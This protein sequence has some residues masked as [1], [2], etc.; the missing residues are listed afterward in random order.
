MSYSKNEKSY[1]RKVV[2]TRKE[3][4]DAYI[5]R[6]LISWVVFFLIGCVIGS[7]LTLGFTWLTKDETPKGETPEIETQVSESINKVEP[8]VISLDVS[9]EN[10]FIPLDVPMNTDL[11]KYIYDLCGNDI[12]FPLVMALIKQESSFRPNVISETDDWGLMQI[13]EINHERL[14]DELGVT[15]Y[16][17]PYENT[18]AGVHLL[19]EL[20]EKYELPVMVLMVYKHGEKGASDLWD[21]GVF[22]TTYTNEILKSADEY[23]QQISGK[24]G[25]IK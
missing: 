18:K 25:E 4:E 24:E 1:G 21:E 12:E 14:T 2:K 15:N 13:N 9:T 7:L 8:P 20:F 19:K 23:R 17:N 11:Q 5:R 3:A 10:D 6:V 22:E 16:L